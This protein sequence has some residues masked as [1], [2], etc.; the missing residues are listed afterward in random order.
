MRNLLDRLG[1]IRSTI[2]SKSIL[3]NQKK[4]F[5]FTESICEVSLRRRRVS[6]L[7]TAVKPGGLIR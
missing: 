3:A 2:E 5:I 7:E 6:G 1:Q 4:A